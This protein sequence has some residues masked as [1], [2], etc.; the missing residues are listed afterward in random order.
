MITRPVPAY[1]TIATAM[2]ASTPIRTASIWPV[3]R[4]SST[5]AA[6]RTSMAHPASD[7]DWCCL[8]TCPLAL[9]GGSV[10]RLT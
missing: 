8:S 9:I 4:L 6:T 1:N 3:F 7:Q 10:P 2:T 5:S